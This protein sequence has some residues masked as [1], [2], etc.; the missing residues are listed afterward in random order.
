MQRR[1]RVSTSPKPV[2]S[3]RA[4]PVRAPSPA[5][6]VDG[7]RPVS[8]ECTRGCAGCLPPYVDSQPVRDVGSVVGPEVAEMAGVEVDGQLAHT[9]F[10]CRRGSSR[11]LGAFRSAHRKDTPIVRRQAF[12]VSGTLAWVPR[13]PQYG[14]RGARNVGRQDDAAVRER[15]PHARLLD[16]VTQRVRLRGRADPALPAGMRFEVNNDGRAA[17]ADC[18]EVVSA[19]A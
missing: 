2:L 16:P 4:L 15:L 3:V 9:E 11:R 1:G 17:A 5:P 19:T 18:D 12:A 13:R 7:K 10:S 14:N 8:G 6:R